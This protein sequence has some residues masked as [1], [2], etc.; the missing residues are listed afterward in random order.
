[1]TTSA[2]VATASNES[3]APTHVLLTNDDG[4]DKEGLQ[5]L[6]AALIA[7]GFRVTVMAPAANKSGVG[8][9]VTCHGPVVVRLHDDDGHGNRVYSCAGTPADCVRVAVLS[10]V[11]DPVDVVASGIN[12]GVN[13]GDDSTFSGTIG[14]ALEGALLRIPS[15]AFSQQDDAGDISMVSRGAH[16]FLATDLAVRATRTLVENPPP[17]RVIASVNFPH[18][19]KEPAV[20]KAQLSPFSYQ[21]NWTPAEMLSEDSWNVWAYAKPGH[22]DPEVNTSAGTDY[23]AVIGGAASVSAVRADWDG[24]SDAPTGVN[25]WLDAFVARL[26]A[27]GL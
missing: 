13:M 2:Q 3:G 27:P 18:G 21:R 4:Y 14:A 23:A 19:V 10:D 8:R 16:H 5:A 22:P 7:A 24:L 9:G 17:P 15:I 25:A 6:R 20:Q 11:I 26:G 12:H 1:M